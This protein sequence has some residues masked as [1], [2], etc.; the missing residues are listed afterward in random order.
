MKKK[1]V[2]YKVNDVLSD[3]VLSNTQCVAF[4]SSLLILVSKGNGYPYTFTLLTKNVVTVMQGPI[5]VVTPIT[6]ESN[7]TKSYSVPLLKS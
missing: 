7:T 6:L 3:D 4:I 2:L 1:E 5:S